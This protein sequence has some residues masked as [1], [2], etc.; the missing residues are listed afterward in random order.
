MACWIFRV[1]LFALC[2]LPH[3]PRPLIELCY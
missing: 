3:I 1:N 2:D